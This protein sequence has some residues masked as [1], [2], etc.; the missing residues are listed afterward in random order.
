MTKHERAATP[1]LRALA[2]AGVAHTVRAYDHDADAVAA[3]GGFGAEAALALGVTAE[4]VLK[5]IVVSVDGS[6]GVVIL[7]VGARIDLKAAAAALGGRKAVLADPADAQRATGYVV[8]GISP[9]G[10]RRALPTV[11]DAGATAHGTVLVSAG[12]RGLDAELSPLDLVAL[13]GATVADVS[14]TQG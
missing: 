13:T 14:R 8:G 10:Q 4:R 1:A 2:D 9:L 6:L 7:P 12:R 11:V 5:T 3:A